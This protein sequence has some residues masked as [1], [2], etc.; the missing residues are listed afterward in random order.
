MFVNVM[1]KLLFLSSFSEEISIDSGDLLVTPLYLSMDFMERR[2]MEWSDNS[3]NI[4]KVG[5]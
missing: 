2:G 1:M 3:S 4:P 5:R